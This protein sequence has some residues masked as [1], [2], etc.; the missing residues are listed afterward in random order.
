MRGSPCSLPPFWDF[1]CLSHLVFPQVFFQSTS[2]TSEPTTV[3][4]NPRNGNHFCSVRGW[5]IKPLGSTNSPREIG[6]RPAH[7]M[8]HRQVHASLAP[9]RKVGGSSRD[10]ARAS[11]RR[12]ACVSKDHLPPTSLARTTSLALPCAESSGYTRL[13]SRNR[14]QQ[15]SLVTFRVAFPQDALVGSRSVD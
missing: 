13:S 6:R 15:T 3:K 7:I 1:L 14:V 10:F 4:Q 5:T 12:K 11:C 9:V 2:A 8:F